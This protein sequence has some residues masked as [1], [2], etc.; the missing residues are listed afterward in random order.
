MGLCT[1]GG[2][3]DAEDRDSFDEGGGFIRSFEKHQREKIKARFT[4][5]PAEKVL[6]YDEEQRSHLYPFCNF[7]LP[8]VAL[9]FGVAIGAS[10]TSSLVKLV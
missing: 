4:R 10:A 1:R 8:I 5:K 2:I 9:A 7:A 3:D 6:E